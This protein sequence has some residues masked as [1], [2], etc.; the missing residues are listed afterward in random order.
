MKVVFSHG[1][2]SGPWGT[3]IKKLAAI[4]SSMDFIV[5]SID[6]SGIINPDDRVKHLINHLE[7]EN[8]PIILVGS[9]MGGYVSLVASEIIS[10]KALFLMA[11]ALYLSGYEKQKYK[12]KANHIEI[13]HGW[14]DEVIPFGNSVKFAEEIDC[15]LHMISGDHRLTSSMHKIEDIFKNFIKILKY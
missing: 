12:T 1:K 13:V 10:V 15:T 3:K 14:K 7:K 4:A 6:Y 11:P 5:E 2:E 8:S 9:S